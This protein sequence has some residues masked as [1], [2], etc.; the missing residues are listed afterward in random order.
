M[1]SHTVCVSTSGRPVK[2]AE[3]TVYTERPE[4]TPG[5]EEGTFGDADKAT[6][7]SDN[8][9]ATPAD[10]PVETT[11]YGEAGFFAPS[12]SQFAL[13]I[14]RSGY[15]TRWVRFVDIVGSDPV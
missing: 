7:Y 10:N 2:G 15:G 5:N 9:L 13:R 3:V 8:A 11:I 14:S 1:A 6:I 12:G 4:V